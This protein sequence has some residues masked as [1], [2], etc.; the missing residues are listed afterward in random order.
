MRARALNVWRFGFFCLINKLPFNVA[1]KLKGGGSEAEGLQIGS[2]KV[3]GLGKVVVCR[4]FSLSRVVEGEAAAGVRRDII[5]EACDSLRC[6]SC[7]RSAAVKRDSEKFIKVSARPVS[8]V[9]SRWG[10]LRLHVVEAL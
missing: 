9:I 5:R 8:A 6:S 1:L 2:C 7:S 10:N 4:R 3:G